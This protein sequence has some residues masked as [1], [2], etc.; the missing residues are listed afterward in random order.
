MPREGGIV[1]PNQWPIKSRVRLN[2]DKPARIGTAKA[3]YFPRFTLIGT[4]GRQATELHD[5]RLGFGNFFSIR[6]TISI[7]V[8]TFGRIRSNV[9]VQ[10]ARL[11]ESL[12]IYQSTVLWSFEETENALVSFARE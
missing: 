5:L 7:P 1:R 3:D 4:T 9:A 2:A 10:K 12:A 11:Q 8:F 6:P